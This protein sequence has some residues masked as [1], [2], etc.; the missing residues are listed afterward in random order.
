MPA[1][2]AQVS[3]SGLQQL[4]QSTPGASQ[5]TSAP[6]LHSSG[7]TVAPEDVS[8]MK[9]VPGSMVD[10]HVFEEPDLDGTY[11]V[12]SQGDIS[13]P[14][15]G[16]VK[17]ESCTLREAEGAISTQL[18]KEQILNSPHVTVN[19]DEYSA[20]NIVVLGEVNTPGRFPVL[21]P[22]KLVD[23]LVMA[24]GQTALAGN[25]IAIHRIGQ[26]LEK[27]EIV[28]YARDVNDSPALNV[29][30]SPGDSVLVKKAGIVYVL[31]AVN[32]PGGY[33]MQEAGELNVDQA[34][35][36]ASGT[37]PEAKVGSIRV[38]RKQTDGSLTEFAVDYRKINKGEAASLR[39]R[40][41]DI[42]YVPPSAIKS[43]LIHG[44]Q[45]LSS[46]ASA[47]IYAAYQ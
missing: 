30:I 40:A 35:A 28:H 14:L 20:N 1:V 10:V 25:E 47:S 27:N 34:L 22:R 5:G 29:L 24:G 4:R 26:P 15:A 16:S 37:A 7:P 19:L 3:A 38:L 36:M 17:L 31:G 13:L 2:H 33:V 12:D 23:V 32:R 43:T 21:G 6:A 45:I 11:R 9:L 8:N 18:V 41:Q 44:T 46:A 39:L 42:V